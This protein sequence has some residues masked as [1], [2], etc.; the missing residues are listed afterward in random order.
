MS[1]QIWVSQ[2]P[3]HSK[4]KILSTCLGWWLREYHANFDGTNGWSGVATSK[5]ATTAQQWHQPPHHHQS[6]PATV[7]RTRFHGSIGA[8]GGHMARH[9]NFRK[10]D[11]GGSDLMKRLEF[12]CSLRDF[13]QLLSDAPKRKRHE[14]INGEYYLKFIKTERSH[15]RHLNFLK[16]LFFIASKKSFIVTSSHPLCHRCVI[17]RFAFEQK[18]KQRLCRWR[19]FA[20]MFEWQKRERSSVNLPPNFV[21]RQQIALEASQEKRRKDEQYKIEDLYAHGIATSLNIPLLFENLYKVNGACGAEDTAEA[22]AIQ[23]F[24]VVK[25]DIGRC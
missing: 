3:L 13:W 2:F 5:A 17:T 10:S 25:K 20:E 24:R 4:F 16:H 22:E 18:L 12:K 14:I 6:A 19:L 9:W 8:A 1:Q 11:E 21:P 23:S 15:V 7:I